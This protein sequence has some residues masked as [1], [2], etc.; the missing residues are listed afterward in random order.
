VRWSRSEDGRASR[1]GFGFGFGFNERNEG[2]RRA[3]ARRGEV[4]RY[5]ADRC[6]QNNEPNDVEVDV[7]PVS[8]SRAMDVVKQASRVVS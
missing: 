1:V 5:D 3:R 8:V 6:R 2:M 4:M 7:M